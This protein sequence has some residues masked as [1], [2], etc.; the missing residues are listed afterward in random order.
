MRKKKKTDK[1]LKSNR[2]FIIIILYIPIIYRSLLRKTNANK[3]FLQWQV[4]RRIFL[5]YV[6]FNFFY[7][8]LHVGVSTLLLFFF[9]ISFRSW[10]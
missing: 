9:S 8:I 5:I 3:I 1:T 2:N 6:F 7:S 10:D 4:G